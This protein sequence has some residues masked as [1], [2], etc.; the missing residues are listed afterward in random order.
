[1]N[2]KYYIKLMS[3]NSFEENKSNNKNDKENAKVK[4]INSPE[5]DIPKNVNNQEKKNSIFNNSSIMEIINELI[6]KIS[7]IR[8]SNNQEGESF[9]NND[10][11]QENS[12]FRNNN[13]SKNSLSGQYNNIEN[14][15]NQGNNK[16]YSPNILNCNFTLYEDLTLNNNINKMEENNK[17][18][19]VENTLAKIIEEI[20]EDEKIN[21]SSINN[22]EV[23]NASFISSIINTYNELKDKISEIKIKNE[24]EIINEEIIRIYIY[25]QYYFNFKYNNY[26]KCEKCGK[27][28][29]FFCEN[30]SINLCDICSK[31]CKWK[32]QNKLIKFKDKIEFYKKEIEKIIQEYFSIPKKNEENAEGELT[33]YQLV[34]KYKIIDEPIKRFEYSKDIILI[35]LIINLMK[36]I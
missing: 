22:Q 4:K 19:K 14:S 27:N 35:K 34:N 15:T 23:Q 36:Q 1:M 13:I 9:G 8:Y 18:N 21:V 29:Y 16:T 10:N 31:N 11:N 6:H 30:C 25:Y 7:E 28:N 5:D 17:N 33:N 32:H 26:N 24:N 3:A 12:L 20:E 2:K